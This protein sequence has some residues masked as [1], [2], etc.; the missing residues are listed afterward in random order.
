MAPLRPLQA[1]QPKKQVIIT[2]T[3]PVPDVIDK[4]LARVT[5]SSEPQV[6]QVTC[7]KTMSSYPNAVKKNVPLLPRLS[8]TVT[9]SNTVLGQ[10]F[11]NIII[12]TQTS[13]KEALDI[14]KKAQD[15][16]DKLL[17]KPKIAERL[18]DYVAQIKGGPQIK[19]AAEIKGKMEL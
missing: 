19:A 2:S 12:T 8:T 13:D 9:P 16:V 3:Y 17:D 10:K 4:K 11:S 14:A 15:S 7:F 1:L 6:T 5:Q 18:N